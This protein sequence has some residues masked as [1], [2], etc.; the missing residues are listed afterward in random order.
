[1]LDKKSPRS[2]E[3][4]LPI[5]VSHSRE[6][7]AVIYSLSCLIFWNK[8]TVFSRRVCVCVGGGG[9]DLHLVRLQALTTELRRGSIRTV[10]LLHFCVEVYINLS[11]RC[12]LENMYINQTFASQ[13]LF[14]MKFLVSC[15][16]PLCVKN[17]RT[18]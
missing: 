1:M 2:H 11:T 4:S 15:R 8:S 16:Y 14:T 9:C 5:K 17:E 10:V 3:I 7:G 12:D 6:K 13:Y 18:H